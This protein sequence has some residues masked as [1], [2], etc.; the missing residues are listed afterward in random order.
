MAEASAAR[1]AL[2]HSVDKANP[3][4]R[5]FYERLGFA[6]IDDWGMYELMEWL[7]PGHGANRDA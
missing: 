4:A 1:V 3:D 7:P 2:R 6:V 5:R